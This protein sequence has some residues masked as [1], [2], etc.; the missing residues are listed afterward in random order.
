MLWRIVL[1]RYQRVAIGGRDENGRGGKPIWILDDRFH[2]LALRGNPVS[3]V[4]GRPHDFRSLL[5]LLKHQIRI[6]TRFGWTKG[7]EI[8]HQMLRDRSLGGGFSTH[9]YLPRSALTI[10]RL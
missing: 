1:G 10:W 7:V 5:Q 3:P 4:V 2:C 9:G 8:H 6:G